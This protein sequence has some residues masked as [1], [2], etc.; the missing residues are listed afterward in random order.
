MS[1][2]CLHRVTLDC[3]SGHKGVHHNLETSGSDRSVS[4]LAV[5]AKK[6]HQTGFICACPAVDKILYKYLP[7]MQIQPLFPLM[8]GAKSLQL[9]PTHL[10]P[11]NKA[12][13]ILMAHIE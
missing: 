2:N 8:E 13:T 7:V 4:L 5:L 11:F 10:I 12:L 3:K 6:L 9:R 1:P